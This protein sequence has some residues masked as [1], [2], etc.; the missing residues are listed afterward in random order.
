MRR[1][2]DYGLKVSITAGRYTTSYDAS[3]LKSLQLAFVLAA[4]DVS[5]GE[6]YFSIV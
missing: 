3:Y 1:F 6:H 2:D 4:P 5:G